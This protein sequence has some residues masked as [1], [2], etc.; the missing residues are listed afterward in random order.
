[1]P[2]TMPVVATSSPAWGEIVPGPWMS[3]IARSGGLTVRLI[4]V[5]PVLSCASAIDTGRLLAPGVAPAETVARYEK[6]LSPA[7]TSPF[8]PLSKKDCEAEP[9]IE[10]R[11]PATVMPLD[12]GLVPGV[13]VTVRRV[14]CP[15]STAEGLAAPTPDGFVGPPQKC[16]GEALLR[17]L[18]GPIVKSA[19]L[20]SVSMQPPSLRSAAVVLVSAP[21]AAPSKHVAPS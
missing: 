17:G 15:R 13:T 14:V 8:V 11:F 20:L 12:G 3:W 18:G 6:T 4:E 2:V 10:E 16:A 9:P 21:V 1:M 7:V 19:R 5:A